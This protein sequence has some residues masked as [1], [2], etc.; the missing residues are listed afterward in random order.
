MSTKDDENQQATLDRYGI[1]RVPAD[2]FHFGGYRY[3]NLGDAVAAARRRDERA[4]RT[5][6]PHQ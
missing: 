3:S 2:V 4:L 6:D 5:S 1:V